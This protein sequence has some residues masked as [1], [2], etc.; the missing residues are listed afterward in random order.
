LKHAALSF[1][2]YAELDMSG[3][4]GSL[5][6]AIYRAL[7]RLGHNRTSLRS[8]GVEIEMGMFFNVHHYSSE[9]AAICAAILRRLSVA[10]HLGEW[11]READTLVACD[12]VHGQEGGMVAQVLFKMADDVERQRMAVLAAASHMITYF[13]GR[14]T[15]YAFRGFLSHLPASSIMTIFRSLNKSN[16]SGSLVTSHIPLTSCP[17]GELVFTAELL[18]GISTKGDTMRA[19]WAWWAEWRNSVCSLYYIFS[20][21]EL[22][23]LLHVLANMQSK[24]QLPPALFSSPCT[25]FA[26]ASQP[27]SSGGSI[28]GSH[29]DDKGVA[30]GRSGS[31]PTPTT[32]PTLGNAI[33]NMVEAH[34]PSMTGPDAAMAM[35]AATQLALSGFDADL[36]INMGVILQEYTQQRG[37]GSNASEAVAG[38]SSAAVLAFAP[39]VWAGQPETQQQGSQNSS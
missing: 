13:T 20:S 33:C 4:D 8:K 1:G 3:G 6:C 39:V 18:D 25:A 27:L 38:L 12:S 36:T 24:H 2:T 9:A 29:S 34:L 30:K 35:N 17:P 32:R 5:V 15:P 11:L 19:S 10:V 26:R 16:I 31:S 28:T 23:R 7:H 21:S 22:A 14:T 37:G